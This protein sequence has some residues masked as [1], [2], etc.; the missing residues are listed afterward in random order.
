MKIIVI[1]LF[2]EMFDN[3]LNISMLK[4]AQDKQLVN[5]KY[6]NLRDYGLGKRRQVDDIPYGG[7][8]GMLLKPEPLF[9]A[10]EAAKAE[11][12]SSKVYL[13]TPRGIK[14]N[15]AKAAAIAAS[16]SDMIIVCAHYEGYDERVTT[17]VDEQLS[18]GDYIVT[19]GEIPAMVL[20][21]S[22]VRLLPGV[23]GGEQSAA[24]ESFADGVTLEFPQY[25]R[26]PLFRKLRV[27]K[28]LQN[29]NH[30]EINAWRLRRSRKVKK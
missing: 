8:D 9:A 28:V 1:S 12:P 18:I 10:I 11:L 20:I 17:L 22:V 24:I 13:M 27:P 6:L 21:D 25:T 19:G 4:K 5:I 15:Q 23:L 16:G 2:P 3:V 14:F 26:P 30:A 29:G 7:G